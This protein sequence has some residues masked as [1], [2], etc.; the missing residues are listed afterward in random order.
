MP[1]SGDPGTICD[2]TRD[3]TAINAPMINTIGGE[4]IQIMPN[5]NGRITA[6]MWLI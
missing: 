5:A 4:T 6:A 3:I 1:C 2:S